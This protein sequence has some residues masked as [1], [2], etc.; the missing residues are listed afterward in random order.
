MI[1]AVDNFN[2]LGS[3]LTTNHDGKDIYIYI[4]IEF[5]TPAINSVFEN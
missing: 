3:N 1:A 5:L 4:Y 2:H